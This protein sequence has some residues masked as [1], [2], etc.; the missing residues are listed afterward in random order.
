V[1]RED[2]REP[3][4][5]YWMPVTVR[6]PREILSNLDCGTVRFGS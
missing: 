5:E 6:V 1:R 4:R 3:Q 2:I